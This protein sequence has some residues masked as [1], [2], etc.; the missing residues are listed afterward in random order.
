MFLES[1][2]NVLDKE[3]VDINNIPEDEYPPAV[4]ATEHFDQVYHRVV[5]IE[6]HVS[7]LAEP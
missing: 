7:N 6:S 2:L 1:V 5:G 4:D 3:P